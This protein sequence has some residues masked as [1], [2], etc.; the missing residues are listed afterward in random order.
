MDN[1]QLRSRR[2]QQ[3]S[4]FLLAISFAI[5]LI[6][7][8]RGYFGDEADYL[9]VASSILKGNVL[10]RD[11]F[12]HHF[13]FPYYW[14]AV[15][16]GLFGKSIVAARMSL[17]VFQTLGFGIGMRLGGDCL[18]VSIA[19][20]IWSLLRPCY[21]GNLV[22]YSSFA[23]PALMLVMILVLAVLRDRI[24][25]GWKHWSV[26]GLFSVIAFLS[27]PL[28]IYA[29]TLM[30]VFLFSKKLQWGSI[31][32]LIIIAGFILCLAYLGGSGSLQAFWNQAILFN[33]NVY[34]HYLY[35]TPFRFV[36]LF[37][38][39]VGCLGIT[40]TMWLR[41]N[42]FRPISEEAA[43][44]SQWL[45]TGFLFRF[46]VLMSSLRMVLTRRYRA[47]LFLF[48]FSACTLVISKGGFRAQPFIMIAIM[49]ISMLLA[50]GWRVE[51]GNRLLRMVHRSVFVS[52]LFLAGWLCVRLGMN[53]Y[54]QRHSS[55]IADLET[56]R[57]TMADISA[58]ACGE[59]DVQLALYPY[60]SYE[61]WFTE[62][63]PIAGY[64]YMWPW[65]ADIA[66]DEVISELKRKEILAI[67]SI[68]DGVIWQK[69]DTKVYL[70]SLRDYLEKW[71]TKVAND[72]YISPEL[73]KR[74]SA[75]GMFPG[76]QYADSAESGA[77]HADSPRMKRKQEKLL[78][79]VTP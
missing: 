17:L 33:S 1:L 74:C 34:N 59:S 70:K 75:R 23:A 54:S 60:G 2:A 43:I 44:L 68:R 77:D 6:T 31:T 46:A 30:L 5:G 42:P 14:T 56:D 50:D 78:R 26:I 39:I 79:V 10:Y 72:V 41:L 27:D 47:G 69:Y 25:P 67:V 9:V 63:K 48:L 55:G 53:V 12:S 71:Y 40:D 76:K 20:F 73:T 16:I 22:I 32:S 18:S 7:L 35:T 21:K 62:M 38:M 3:I 29:V 8:R 28:S 65:V 15:I 51:P 37:N 61:Y 11:V 13:P 24:N 57:R 49:A 64:T 52:T 4:W 19:A 45:F 58:F 36:D 66:L